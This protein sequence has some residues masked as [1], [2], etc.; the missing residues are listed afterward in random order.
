MMLPNVLIEISPPI[1]YSV[2]GSTATTCVYGGLR[3]ISSSLLDGQ[4]RARSGSILQT[5]LTTQQ[6]SQLQPP[7]R[8]IKHRQSRTHFRALA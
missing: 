2:T 6:T 5:P 8:R 7:I 3:S 1:S 4:I